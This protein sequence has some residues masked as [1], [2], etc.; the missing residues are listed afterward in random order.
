MAPMLPVEAR[1]TPIV[2]NTY[3]YPALSQELGSKAPYCVENVF[4]LP[5]WYMPLTTKVAVMEY[6]G[7]ALVPD[8]AKVRPTATWCSTVLAPTV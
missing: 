7:V 5:G 2:G 4:S 8:C 6:M 1:T 3:R